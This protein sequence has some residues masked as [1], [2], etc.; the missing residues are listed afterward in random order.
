MVDV[1]GLVCKVS[2]RSNC[3]AAGYFVKRHPI[4]HSPFLN[5]FMGLA[6]IIR[7]PLIWKSTELTISGQWTVGFSH[8]LRLSGKNFSRQKILA[9]CSHYVKIP[10]LF[11]QVINIP[12]QSVWVQLRLLAIINK[13]GKLV[14]KNFFCHEMEWHRVFQR[15]YTLLQS[16]PAWEEIK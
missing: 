1:E 4:L 15:S 7:V 14:D 2:L 16:W 9:N 12:N 3:L 6:L 11:L 10:M 5:Y 8:F 13:F